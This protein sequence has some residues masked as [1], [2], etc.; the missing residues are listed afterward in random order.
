LG[1][2]HVGGFGGEQIAHVAAHLRDTEQPGFVV[3]QSVEAL[4]G[5]AVGTRQVRRDAGVEVARSRGHRQARRWR[6]SHAGVD[7]V[8][9]V[10][11]GEACTAAQMG[12]DHPALC[13]LGAGAAR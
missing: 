2:A 5:Q 4:C 10:H 9:G 7:A 8:A 6:E 11:G 1:R 12:K 13:G 3:R